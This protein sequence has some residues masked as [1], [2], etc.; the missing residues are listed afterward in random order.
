MGKKF[1]ELVIEGPFLSIKGFICGL[2]SG[3]GAA[4][5]VWFSRE[6]HIKAETLAE[7]LMEWTHLHETLCHLVVEES[8]LKDIEEGLTNTA[9]T[10]HLRLKSVRV[11]ES[12]SFAFHY[13]AFARHYGEEIKKVFNA[14]PS[15]LKLSAD[16][17]VKEEIDPSGKGLE[18]YAPCHEYR[19]Q[20]R[21][22]I[23]GPIDAVVS[24]C[25][26]IEEYGLIKKEQIVL[27]LGAAD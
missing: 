22:S 16:Y 26:K 4:G 18:A 2:R 25:R 13:D 5:T 21:G 27:H 11:I 12:A 14:L 1:Y 7:H 23:A 20:G 9:D 24:F 17:Q 10:L 6:E 3:S 8:L 15:E 19:C